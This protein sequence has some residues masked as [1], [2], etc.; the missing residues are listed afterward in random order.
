MKLYMVICYDFLICLSKTK[1]WK[2]ANMS[3]ANHF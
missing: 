3:T 2:H 1:D